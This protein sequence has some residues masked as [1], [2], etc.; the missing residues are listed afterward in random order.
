MNEERKIEVEEVDG[1]AAPPRARVLVLNAPQNPTGCVLTDADRAA[2]AQLA[3]ERDL[4]VVTDEI[5]SAITFSGVTPPSVA[6]LPGM[7]S[8]TVLVD[9]FSKTYAMT[10]YRLG[11]LISPRAWV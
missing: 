3:L 1:V 7:A 4:T 9:G 5:Y 2:V 10:G 8:R 11:Y 6:G